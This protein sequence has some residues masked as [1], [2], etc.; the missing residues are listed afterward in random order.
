MTLAGVQ[1][2]LPAMVKLLFTDVLNCGPATP[3]K[4]LWPHPSHMGYHPQHTILLVDK[5]LSTF[6]PK[7]RKQ[8][9]CEAKAQKWM[10]YCVAGV[11]V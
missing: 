1:S 2:Q 11:G 4:T 3:S 9:A 10:D 8:Q 5:N 7:R 6:E